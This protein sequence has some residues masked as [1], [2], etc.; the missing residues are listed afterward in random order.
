MK[1]KDKR[2]KKKEFD[3]RDVLIGEVFEYDNRYYIN[4]TEVDKE[5]G[6][7]SC[8]ELKEGQLVGFPP[9]TTVKIVSAEIVITN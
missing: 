4:T 6:L 2:N 7:I 9:S 8:V 3:L 1:I 5:T